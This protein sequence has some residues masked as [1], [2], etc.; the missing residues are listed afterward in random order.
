MNRQKER[1]PMVK[2]SDRAAAK[3]SCWQ[4]VLMG[5]TPQP[6]AD[7]SPRGLPTL[8][9]KTTT[10]G[11]RGGHFRLGDKDHQRGTSETPLAYSSVP[12]PRLDDLALDVVVAETHTALTDTMTPPSDA[13]ATQ[14]RRR[15]LERASP[16]IAVAA[17]VTLGEDVA[18]ILLRRDRPTWGQPSDVLHHLGKPC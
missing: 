9:A 2:R 5:P 13:E 18:E 6:K 7:P 8:S 14:Q 15:V 16:V 1:R 12:F 17:R 3:T 4:G 11:L 10:T